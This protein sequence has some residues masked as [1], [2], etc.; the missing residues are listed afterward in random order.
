MTDSPLPRRRRVHAAAAA[1]VALLSVHHQPAQ[2]QAWP[3]RPIRLIVTFPP[4]NGADVIAREIAPM[5]AQR[6]GQPVVV[7]NRGGAGGVIGAGRHRRGWLGR[8]DRRGDRGRREYGR[9]R[10]GVLRRSG[11]G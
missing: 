2:A 3:N 8:S 4:G 5:L 6:L 9:E 11:C 1:L 10:R 7:E